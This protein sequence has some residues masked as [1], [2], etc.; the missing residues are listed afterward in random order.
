MLAMRM[1]V[2]LKNQCDV[3]DSNEEIL[4]LSGVVTPIKIRDSYSDIQKL[5]SK[6]KDLNLLENG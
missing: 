6:F 2:Q 1:R 4:T 5:L 3:I